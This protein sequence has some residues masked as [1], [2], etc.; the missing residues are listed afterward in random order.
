MCRNLASLIERRDGQRTYKYVLRVR[1]A[2][3][4]KGSVTV[5]GYTGLP[6]VDQALSD[7]NGAMIA[8][9]KARHAYE[10]SADEF[11]LFSTRIGDCYAL[12]CGFLG[13]D[14]YL[15]FLLPQRSR[16]NSG[17]ATSACGH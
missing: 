1:A 14:Q 2:I 16:T 12:I 11:T 13:R 10:I 4:E 8:L 17:S 6:N 7:L 9:D 3:T 5:T 15:N